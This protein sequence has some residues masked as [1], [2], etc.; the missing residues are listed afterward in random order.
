MPTEIYTPSAEEV[1]SR[2]GRY[3]ELTPMSTTDDL[4]WVPDE[5]W[6]IFF[7][8]KIMA[9]VLEDTESPFGNRAPIKT[10][11]GLTMFI[12]ILTPGQGPCLH[13]H[14]DT[15]ETFMVLKGSIEYRVGDPIAHRRVLNQWDVFSC[16]PGVYREFRNV[17]DED[18]VQLTILTGPKERNDVTIPHSVRERVVAEYGEKVADAFGEIMPFDPP[19]S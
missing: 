6:D 10:A 11:N 12:S 7:A 19:A 16:P 4:D 9:V 5:A 1:D 14:N 17:G 3:D 13:D 18:A 8:R 2:I 15:Y